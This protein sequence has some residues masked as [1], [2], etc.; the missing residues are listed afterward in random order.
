MTAP[1]CPHDG[2][3]HT[4]PPCQRKAGRITDDKPGELTSA[5]PAAY[6]GGCAGCVLPVYVGQMIRLDRETWRVFHAEGCAP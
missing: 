3:P 6:D 1:E 4:C 2:D 5:F